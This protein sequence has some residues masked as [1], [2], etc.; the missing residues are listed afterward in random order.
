M[1][2]IEYRKNKLQCVNYFF[3]ISD[4]DN[5]IKLLYLQCKYL[6]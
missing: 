2:P 5:D 3:T 1:T 4:I 6:H